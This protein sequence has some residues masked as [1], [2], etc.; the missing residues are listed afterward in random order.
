[1]AGTLGELATKRRKLLELYY[2]DRISADLFADETRLAQAI[3]AA[4]EEAS[5]E[6]EASQRCD[7]LA[8]RFEEVA[9]VLQDIEIDR[10]WTEATDKERRVLIE[11]LVEAVAFFPDHLEVTIAGAPKLNVGLSEVGLKEPESRTVGVGGAVAPIRTH[12]SLG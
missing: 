6:A 12:I 4:R 3:E 8:A 7:G 1:M 2:N 5:G 11:E 9:R 10:F